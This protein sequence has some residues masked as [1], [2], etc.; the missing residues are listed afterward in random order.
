MNYKEVFESAKFGDKFLTKNGEEAVF[1]RLADNSEYQF[2][3]LYV[4]NWGIIQVFRN[5]G[6]CTHDYKEFDI[7]KKVKDVNSKKE[8]LLPKWKKRPSQAQWAGEIS[9]DTDHREFRYENYSINAD[10]LFKK[11]DKE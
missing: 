10:E 3:I 5:T 8:S 6:C 2:A 11:M 9:V 4:N 7:D 1:L